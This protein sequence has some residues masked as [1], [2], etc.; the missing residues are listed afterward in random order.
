MQRKTSSN[1][2]RLKLI[3]MAGAGLLMVI[4]THS[5]FAG[6]Y[7]DELATEAEATAAVS[8]KSQ[9][10]P[11]EKAQFE[12]MESQLKSEKP[13]TYKYYVKLKQSNKERAFEMFAGDS[14]A[15]K[16]RLSHLQKKVM[17]LYFSQ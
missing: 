9:L 7:L 6:G 8:K 13:S 4:G 12:E 16:D 14:S 11:A 1:K 5:L 17:D 3:A 15:P 10:S 2:F